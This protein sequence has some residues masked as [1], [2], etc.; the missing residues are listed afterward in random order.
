[1]NHPARRA[2][3][4][5]W[6]EAGSLDLRH[7]EGGMPGRHRSRRNRDRADRD[8]LLEHEYG[9]ALGRALAIRTDGVDAHPVE[10]RVKP[11]RHGHGSECFSY[12]F[13]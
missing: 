5:P 11:G 10:P 6:I 8:G 1:M 4:E 7:D 9:E 13:G 12:G 3:N 2:P